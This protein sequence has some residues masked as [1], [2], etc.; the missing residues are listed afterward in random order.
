MPPK[1]TALWYVGPIR[2]NLEDCAPL[3]YTTNNYIK[4]EF[5]KI[6]NRCLKIIDYNSSKD[7]TRI[8]FNIPNITLRFEYLYTLSFYK[9]LNSLVPIIDNGLMPEKSTSETRLAKSNEFIL[10]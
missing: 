6:E 9:L 5:L 7:S 10:S 3:L 8:S 4:N 2:S 1:L